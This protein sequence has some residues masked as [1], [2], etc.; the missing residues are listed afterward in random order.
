MML[1][2][3]LFRFTAIDVH[4]TDLLSGRDSRKALLTVIFASL[5]YCPSYE[6]F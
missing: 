3:K 6:V 2:W 1:T 4:M 5:N